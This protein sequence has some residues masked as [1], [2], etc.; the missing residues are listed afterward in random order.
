MAAAM[1]AG[2]GTGGAAAAALAAG[3]AAGLDPAGTLIDAMRYSF[4]RL[5]MS[6]PE[7]PPDMLPPGM[8]AENMTL[9]PGM[10]METMLQ[11]VMQGVMDSNRDTERARC[12]RGLTLVHFSAQLEPFL[13]QIT[14]YTPHDDP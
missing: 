11:T 12:R 13:T 9:P 10:T 14:P 1:V 3:V 7:I 4:Q 5:G 8:T 2:A 6:M